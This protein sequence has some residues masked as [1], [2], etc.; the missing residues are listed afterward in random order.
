MN[1][2]GVGY[3]KR[4]RTLVSSTSAHPL[5]MATKVDASLVFQKP[6]KDMPPHTNKKL[7]YVPKDVIKHKESIC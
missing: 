3:V 6:T 7:G 4:K 1:L 2:D 5:K